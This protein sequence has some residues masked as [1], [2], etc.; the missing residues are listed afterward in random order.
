MPKSLCIMAVLAPRAL[1]VWRKSFAIVSQPAGT[2]LVIASPP[3]L[4]TLPAAHAAHAGVADAEV[5]LLHVLV[6]LEPLGAALEHDAPILEHIAEIGDVESH[7]RVLLDEQH[8]GA[9][10]V[11][12]PADDAV[13]LPH[14]Q[15]R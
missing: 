15:R 3:L 14:E 6:A 4:A 9:A 2:T 11:L 5:E 8:R 1:T 12:E 13:D 10:F 7:A